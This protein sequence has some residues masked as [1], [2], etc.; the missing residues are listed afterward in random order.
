MLWYMESTCHLLQLGAPEVVGTSGAHTNL[1]APTLPYDFRMDTS[2]LS[3]SSQVNAVL[4]CVAG[5]NWLRDFG[6]RFAMFWVP[7]D[8][9]ALAPGVGG[10]RVQSA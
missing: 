9:A 7:G 1:P 6:M 4:S 10:S 5:W 8:S 3:G 2:K